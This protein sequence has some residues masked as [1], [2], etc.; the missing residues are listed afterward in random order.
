MLIPI[1][2]HIHPFFPAPLCHELHS[3]H[4]FVILLHSSFPSLTLGRITALRCRINMEN[5]FEVW[6]R[7][8]ISIPQFQIRCYLGCDGNLAW[9]MGLRSPDHAA[10][11]FI[12][13]A[14]L[15]LY[16]EVCSDNVLTYAVSSS[17]S[18]LTRCY[19]HRRVCK[20]QLKQPGKENTQNVNKTCI[21]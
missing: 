10:G 17:G 4:Q 2:L 3:Y 20:V 11:H 12:K 15:W 21:K 19:S 9:I 1:F 18:Y 16:T 13:A 6:R 14:V 8:S 5:G 7:F